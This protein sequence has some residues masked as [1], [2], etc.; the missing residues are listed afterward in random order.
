MIKRFD[1]NSEE[2]SEDLSGN[3]VFI[4]DDSGLDERP[5]YVQEFYERIGESFR[6]KWP[7]DSKAEPII[8]IEDIPEGVSE[9]DIESALSDMKSDGI[10]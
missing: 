8:D 2:L 6:V 7:A 4:V 3:G 9:S 10:I 1:Y 5:A